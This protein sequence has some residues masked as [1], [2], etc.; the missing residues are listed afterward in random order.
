L[1]VHMGG[2]VFCAYIWVVLCLQSHVSQVRSSKWQIDESEQ[3]SSTWE[4]R[5]WTFG[6]MGLMAAT[7]AQGLVHVRSS[8]EAVAV[9]LSLAAAYVLADLGTGV[10]DWMPTDY[11]RRIMR[12]A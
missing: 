7:L 9:A 11:I 10:W 5:A 2:V 8:E 12:L 1:C 3:L 4:H 6:S